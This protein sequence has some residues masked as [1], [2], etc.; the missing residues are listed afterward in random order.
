MTPEHMWMEYQSM[1]FETM[2]GYEL[3]FEQ[4]KDKSRKCP[5]LENAAFDDDGV[6]SYRTFLT[7]HQKAYLDSVFF[8]RTTRS[9][10][11]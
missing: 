9:S 5:Q 8:K 2:P 1:I 6:V 4:A 7:V 3:Y 10:R 11:S